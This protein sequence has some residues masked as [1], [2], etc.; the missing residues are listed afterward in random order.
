MCEQKTNT[1]AS[2][3]EANLGCGPSSTHPP[4]P[5]STTQLTTGGLDWLEFSVWGD[6]NP[7]LMLNQE[8]RLNEAQRAAKQGDNEHAYFEA[9]GYECRVLP[10]GR[11][12]GNAYL[13]YVFE[14]QGV[15]FRIDGRPKRKADTVVASIRIGS[16]ALTRHAPQEAAEDAL[17]LLRRIF[18]L[19]VDHT[20]VSRIDL[21]VDLPDVDPRPLIAKLVCTRHTITKATD[22]ATYAEYGDRAHSFTMGKTIRC[23]VYDKAKELRDKPDEQKQQAIVQHRWGGGGRECEVRDTC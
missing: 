7:T 22:H 1:S 10:V 21:C 11:R 18:G 12:H 14:S 17:Q 3:S 6:W 23:R 13:H 2:V 8:R 15:Q 20:C 4:N 19:E 16:E 9:A 5:H